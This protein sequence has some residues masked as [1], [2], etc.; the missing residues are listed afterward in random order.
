MKPSIKIPLLLVLAL[1]MFNTKAQENNKSSF[2]LQ[3]AIDYALAH[4][5]NYQNAELDV[6]SAD[7]KNKE[8][9]GIGLP[10]ISGSADLKD[11]L[12]IPTTMLPGDFFGKLCAR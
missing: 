6:K 1:V 7:Y 9:T 5:Q 11:Y 2:S 10:Q 12:T 4:N 3:E 8:I